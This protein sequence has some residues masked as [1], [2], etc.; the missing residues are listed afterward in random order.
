MGSRLIV[1]WRA[2][3]RAPYNMKLKDICKSMRELLL[4]CLNVYKKLVFFSIDTAQ[5]RSQL[6]VVVASSSALLNFRLSMHGT[7]VRGAAYKDPRA[8]LQNSV[9]L[10][11]Y[12]LIIDC[13][14]KG[15]SRWDAVSFLEGHS[16][17]DLSIVSFSTSK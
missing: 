9:T 15:T 16:F 1:A 14:S 5:S 7:S 4:F 6:L 3:D 8:C 12:K 2:G 13:L 17:L 11:W 10:S